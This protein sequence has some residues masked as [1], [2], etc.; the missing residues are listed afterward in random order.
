MVSYKNT[1]PVYSVAV[2]S[3]NRIPVDVV[4]T[5]LCTQEHSKSAWK[6]SLLRRLP[7]LHSCCHCFLR[8]TSEKNPVLQL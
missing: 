1:L 6:V 8:S 2:G 7:R 5:K 3:Q 4:V